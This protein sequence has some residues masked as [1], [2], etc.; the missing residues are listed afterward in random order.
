VISGSARS[1]ESGE[2]IGGE[3]PERR[4]DHRSGFATDC[5][6][7]VPSSGGATGC[8][9][10]SPWPPPPAS[11][12][13]IR[14]DR[15][16]TLH[17]RARRRALGPCGSDGRRQPVCSRRGRRGGSRGTTWARPEACLPVGP[18][19]TGAR[20]TRVAEPGDSPIGLY[21]SPYTSRSRSSY[22]FDSLIDRR[23]APVSRRQPRRLVEVRPWTKN[24]GVVRLRVLSGSERAARARRAGC[25]V[26]GGP[27]RR[28]RGPRGPSD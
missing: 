8:P 9:L 19:D 6:S 20:C 12:P 4:A 24:W 28:G 5:G 15:R 18:A 11:D 26:R 27:Q 10:V 1:P 14:H 21:T 17:G 7:S 13:Q 2:L 16:E 25:G 3:T 22:S 23:W